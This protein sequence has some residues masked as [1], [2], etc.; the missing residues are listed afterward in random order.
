M[1]HRRRG[2]VESETLY[3]CTLRNAKPIETGSKYEREIRQEGRQRS[4]P[5]PYKYIAS[6]QAA[7]RNGDKGR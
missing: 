5:R 4:P 7:A 3:P 1:I 2:G 6:E